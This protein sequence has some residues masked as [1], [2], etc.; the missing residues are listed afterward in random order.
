MF[1]DHWSENISATC[2][3]NTI[4]YFKITNTEIGV[5]FYLS[6][7][8]VK[9]DPSPEKWFYIARISLRTSLEKFISS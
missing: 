9:E 2:K 4:R 5:H 7:L 1:S 3:R 6:F 8:F